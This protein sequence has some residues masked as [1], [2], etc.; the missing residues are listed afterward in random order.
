MEVVLGGSWTTNVFA[1]YGLG[2]L[3]CAFQAY[4]PS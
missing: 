3:I 2:I 1:V 4:I